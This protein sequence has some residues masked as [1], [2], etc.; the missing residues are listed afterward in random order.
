MSTFFKDLRVVELAGVL[1]GPAAGMFFAELGARVVKI[2]SRD[3]GDVTRSWKLEGE[4]PSSP[5]SAYFA[6]INYKKEYWS[7][8]LRDERDRAE[9]FAELKDA[10]VVLTSFA[11]GRDVELGLDHASVAAINPDVIYARITGFGEDSPRHAFDV[12]LQAEAG[13]MSMNGTAESG[14]LKMPV[15]LI[16]VLAAHHLKEAI[17][18][19]LLKRE[20]TGEGSYVGV[21]LYDAALTSLANQAT[22]Y[23]MCAYVPQPLG[24]LH[25]CIA[26]YGETI[27]TADGLRIVLAVGAD[28]QFEALCAVCGHPAWAED[29]RFATNVARVKHRREL[30]DLIGNACGKLQAEELGRRLEQEGVPYGLVRSLDQVLAQDVAQRLI[31]EETIQGTLTRRLSSIAFGTA[32]LDRSPTAP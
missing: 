29:E 11:P 3:G 27:E 16:D 5:V 13:F 10:D 21:S 32:F 14:P 30:A 2:E 1:A 31:R 22:A 26:P 18:L 6:A 19:A 8:D 15:A 20:R 17:L 25:P 28:R 12:V 24:T 23:L 7:K 4:D 9:V